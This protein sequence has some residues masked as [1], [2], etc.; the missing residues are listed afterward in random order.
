MKPKLSHDLIDLMKFDYCETNKRNNYMTNKR[1]I[2]YNQLN[3][4]ITLVNSPHKLSKKE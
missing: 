4:F 1:N 3:N 2:N